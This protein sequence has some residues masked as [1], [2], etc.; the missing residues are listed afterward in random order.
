VS[1]GDEPLFKPGGKGP[2]GERSVLTITIYFILRKGKKGFWELPPGE[3][4]FTSSF[5]EKE[6]RFDST[7]PSSILLK[8]SKVIF[9]KPSS[10]R[11]PGSGFG[12]DVRPAG[13]KIRESLT[14]PFPKKWVPGE[15]TVTLL[16]LF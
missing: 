6:E 1:T 8:R 16:L 4:T 7:F 11:Q 13:F 14:L 10:P 2:G 9:L 15:E 5:R 12:M 3:I